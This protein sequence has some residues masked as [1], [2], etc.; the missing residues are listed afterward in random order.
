MNEVGR[1][2][3][4]KSQM[5]CYLHKGYSQLGFL[6]HVNI[7]F[8]IADCITKFINRYALYIIRIFPLQTRRIG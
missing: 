4:L 6:S 8:K 5:I 2:F 3:N 7:P 1:P